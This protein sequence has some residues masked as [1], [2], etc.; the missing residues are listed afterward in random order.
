LDRAAKERRQLARMVLFYEYFGETAIGSLV[1]S[2]RQD[3]CAP[4]LRVTR[5]N[6]YT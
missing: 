1:E 3:A 5:D 4:A 2:C 6:R